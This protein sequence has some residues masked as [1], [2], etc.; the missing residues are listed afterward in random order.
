M[1]PTFLE[2]LKNGPVLVADGAT[3]TGL[4]AA[5][6]PAGTLPE[7]WNL[8]RPEVIAALHRAYLDAGARIVLTNTF[9][10]NRIKL[11]RAGRTELAADTNRRAA[12]IAVQVAGP[13][14][15]LVGGDVGPSGELLEPM[16]NLTYDE[17][18]RAFAEQVRSLEEG[19]VDCIWIETFSDLSEAHAAIQGAQQAT[20]LPIVCTFSFDSHGRTMMGV[21]PGKAAEALASLGLAAIGSNCGASLDDTLQA[22]RAMAAVLPGMPLV[23]KP[24]AGLPRLVGNDSVY[25]TAPEEMARYAA[26]YVQEGARIVGGCCGSTPAHIA[27][28]AQKVRE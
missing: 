7:E 11:A 12:E 19:G 14:G 28:I 27:A 15:A 13:Y 8:S 6:L 16:G 26:L 9:G 10:G 17:A 24:N 20:S 18:V 2:L 22:V 5:G 1:S 25:D 4:Q 23:A 3:G 21:T